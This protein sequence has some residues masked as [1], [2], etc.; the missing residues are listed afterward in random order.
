MFLSLCLL[1]S[2][3]AARAGD[4]GP[5]SPLQQASDNLQRINTDELFGDESPEARPFLI[6]M[7]Q[8]LRLLI[9][10]A[11]QSEQGQRLD[12]EQAR[13][14]VHDSIAALGLRVDSRDD[15]YGYGHIFGVTLDMP[16]GQDLFLVATTE[17]S[18]NCGSD[19][20][21]YLFQ[22]QGTHWRLVLSQ[23]ATELEEAQADLKY[24]LLGRGV[25]RGPILVAAFHHPCHGTCWSM[26]RYRVTR[27]GST[28]DSPII[29]GTGEHSY[30][31]CAEW[32]LAQEK[33]GFSLVLIDNEENTDFVPRR[34]LY[35]IENEQVVLEGK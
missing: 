3:L 25:G 23:E 15:N 11:I 18:V 17:L 12:L 9:E 27:I 14:R 24:L 2:L 30:Y 19:T 6:A 1:A 13:R 4:S 26:L 8:Q 20:S 22:R 28:P 7:K 5:R 34:L 31:R 33:T 29:L 21:F 10:Q 35:K 16:P 32:T